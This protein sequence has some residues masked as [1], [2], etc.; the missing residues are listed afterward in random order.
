MADHVDATA[1]PGGPALGPMT[2]TTAPVRLATNP[3]TGPAPGPGG[4]PARL[5][6]ET[7]ILTRRSPIRIRNEPETLSDVTIGNP[8]LSSIDAWPMQHPE[9]YTVLWAIGVVVVFAP[10]AVYLYRRRSRS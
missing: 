7:W 3:A 6:N 4:G 9:A 10:V 5:A 8:N 2:A 1:G